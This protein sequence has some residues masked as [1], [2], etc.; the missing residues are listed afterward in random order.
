MI[1]KTSDPWWK[2]PKGDLHRHIKDMFTGIRSDD[3]TRLQN[4]HRYLQMYAGRST[5]GLSAV[6]YYRSAADPIQAVQSVMSQDRV[7]WNLAKALVD[8]STAKVG[9]NRPAP[10]VLTTDA[11]AGMRRRSKKLQQG[12]YSLLRTNR[13]HQDGTTFF[14]DGAL[15][16]DIFAHH[17]VRHGIIVSERVF[18]WELFV[19]PRESYK[20]N[21]RT[22]MRTM[23]VDRH[24]ALDMFKGKSGAQEAITSSAPYMDQELLDSNSG[25]TNP[26]SDMIEL[27]EA[28]HLP[29]SPDAK[30]GLHVIQAD[31]GLIDA[32]RYNR[33]KFPFTRFSW[34]P[35]STG[36][37]SQG[38]VEEAR[39][40]QQ[41]I[42]RMLMDIHVRLRLGSRP[43][44]VEHRGAKVQAK[45]TNREFDRVLYSGSIAPDI[46]VYATS[47]PEYYQHLERQWQRGFEATGVSQLFSSSQIPAGISGSG[48]SLLVYNDL[49]SSR[50][51]PV[52]QR[53]ENFHMD[54]CEQYIDL[55]DDMLEHGVDLEV[56]T[57]V[58]R[59]RA[60]YVKKL[61]WSDINMES[62]TYEMQV[63]P[64]S[65]LPNEPAGRQAIVQG[66]IQMGVIDKKFAQYLLDIPDT[67]SYINLELASLDVILDSI[68][69]IIE[70]QEPI[71]PTPYDDHELAAKLSNASLHRAR[72]DKE[73]EETLDL[74]RE[75]HDAA[76]EYIQR[77]QAEASMNQ[78]MGGAAG[79][80]A[81]AGV[82]GSA[83]G[84]AAAA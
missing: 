2:K 69:R 4:Y 77:G 41:E 70:N 40:F 24:V 22:M 75:F 13:I 72:L 18:P 64:I 63:M 45:Y 66:W 8:S 73:P 49:G 47:H 55:A 48:K 44:I 32:H 35:C 53:W 58:Q 83:A 54:T 62:D 11:D 74:L 36:Y 76:I 33:A 84:I 68:E 21:P 34:S 43:V 78:P 67:D 19:D 16:G 7:R 10:H 56:K 51:V 1:T 39:P 15:Y 52:S 29:S 46:R 28:W 31:G 42:N 17:G 82:D 9:K 23:L 80:G 5:P 81:G 79:P 61:H 26:Y 25:R 71:K 12:L 37:W 27:I 57:L 20:G 60:K 6:S 50:F 59:R 3:Q 38:L 65:S 14:R 30:D